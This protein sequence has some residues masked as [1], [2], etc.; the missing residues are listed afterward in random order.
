MSLTALR[1]LL[2]ADG[3]DLALELLHNVEL[4][5]SRLKKNLNRTRKAAH[6]LQAIVAEYER[7]NKALKDELRYW[8]SD[9]GSLYVDEWGTPHKPE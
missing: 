9:H 3:T 5:I 8:K 1:A 7:E 6:M 2:D 4:Q